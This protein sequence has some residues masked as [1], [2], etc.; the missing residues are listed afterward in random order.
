MIRQRR[1]ALE[2]RQDAVAMA[3]GVGVM[4]VSALERGKAS[5]EVGKVLA[6]LNAV[7]LDVY[8]KTRA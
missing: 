8:L 4:F 3:A 5:A 6:V 7:G 2:L 1:K